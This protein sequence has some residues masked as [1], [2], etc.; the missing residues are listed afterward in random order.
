MRQSRIIFETWS[1]ILPGICQILFGQDTKVKVVQQC[2]LGWI[3]RLYTKLHPEE[4]MNVGT[5][6]NDNLA[7]GCEIL[8]WINWLPTNMLSDT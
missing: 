7:N 8:V 5:N 1:S 3:K 6:S 2:P 4:T